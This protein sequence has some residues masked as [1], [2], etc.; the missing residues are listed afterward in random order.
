MGLPP[1]LSSRAYNEQV[2]NIAHH[3]VK[4]TEKIMLESAEKLIK[5]VEREDQTKIEVIEGG[6]KVAKVAVTVDGTWQK[7]GHSSSIGVVF[8][9]AVRTGEVLDYSLKSVSC[10]ECQSHEH[11]HKDS[12]QYKNWLQKHRH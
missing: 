9:T 11:D 1:P 4:I 7:R 3:A 5:V 10:H 8:V 6:K 12:D 2:K